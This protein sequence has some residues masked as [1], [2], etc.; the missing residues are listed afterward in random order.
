MESPR[1]AIVG[2]VV[3]AAAFAMLK[4]SAFKSESE[5][6]DTLSHN[7]DNTDIPSAMIGSI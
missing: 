1:T 6:L 5:F 2:S 7:C 4:Q 3:V